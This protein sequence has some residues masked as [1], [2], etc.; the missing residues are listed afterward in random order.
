MTLSVQTRRMAVAARWRRRPEI[1][2]IDREHDARHRQVA[3]QVA[4]HCS[5]PLERMLGPMSSKICP[6]VRWFSFGS[7]GWS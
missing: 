5:G 7:M 6:S 4:F 1:A 2:P 3:D